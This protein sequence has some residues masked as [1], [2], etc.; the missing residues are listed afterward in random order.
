VPSTKASA[1]QRGFLGSFL[2][3]VG[4]SLS[5]V[6]LRLFVSC[7]AVSSKV[8]VLCF[9]GVWFWAGPSASS[10]WWLVFEVMGSD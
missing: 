10:F 4:R 3:I 6:D 9:E 8:T 1:G 7:A 5:L 2:L